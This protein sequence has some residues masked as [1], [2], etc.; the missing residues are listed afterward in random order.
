MPLDLRKAYREF[1]SATR[2]PEIITVPPVHYAVVR[3]FGDPNRRNKFLKQ[4]IT[5]LYIV[6]RTLK[7]SYRTEHQIRD[8]VPY[9]MPPLEGFWRQ[10]G[11]GGLDLTSKD[12]LH[13]MMASRLPEFVTREDF[14]WAVRYASAKREMDCAYARFQ[15]I[16]EGLCV[17]CLHIGPY[18]EENGT[19]GRMEEFLSANG[20]AL[21]LTEQRQHHEIYLSDAR[22]I[23]AE[24]LRTLLRQPIRP[25]VREERSQ[26]AFYE[27][28]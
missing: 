13:W 1:Y 26:E 27:D 17:Q 23:P 3:G 12:R 21:D 16:E 28:A 8:F 24:R 9:V 11:E 20:Y 4:A 15:T 6:G 10:T 14:D 25:C 5:I 2:Q 18:A 22:K 7:M 19:A